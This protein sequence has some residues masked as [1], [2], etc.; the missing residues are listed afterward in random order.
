MTMTEM[1]QATFERRE[2]LQSET[3]ERP[4][5]CCGKTFEIDGV[6]KVSCEIQMAQGHSTFMRP[7]LRRNWLLNGKRIAAAKLQKMV[8]A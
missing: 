3:P 4:I 6:G 8:G 5:W 7:H 2:R 1:L